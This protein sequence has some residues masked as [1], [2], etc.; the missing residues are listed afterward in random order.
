MTEAEDRKQRIFTA[1]AGYMERQKTKPVP[2]SMPRRNEKTRIVR[3][4]SR[5]VRGYI[6]PGG[7]K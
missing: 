7:S 6:G 5:F 3:H 2:Q 1:I 4:Y